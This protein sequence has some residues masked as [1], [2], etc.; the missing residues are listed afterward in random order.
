[1]HEEEESLMFIEQEIFFFQKS[2]ICI[3]TINL[4]CTIPIL[5]VN[6]LSPKEVTAIKS[7]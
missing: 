2:L 4:G 7:H 5:W 1:M 3:L 6:N